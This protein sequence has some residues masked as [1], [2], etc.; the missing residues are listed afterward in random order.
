MAYVTPTLREES[1]GWHLEP[2]FSWLGGED[3]QLTAHESLSTCVQLP[4][5]EIPVTVE[6]RGPMKDFN[7][8]GLG[9]LCVSEK[10]RQTILPFVL[11]SVQFIPARLDAPGRWYIANLLRS[12]DC[13][14]PERS[15]LL[16][17]FPV[18]HPRAGDYSSVWQM[19]I[20]ESACR[21][22]HWFRPARWLVAELMSKEAADAVQNARI[23]GIDFLPTI[24]IP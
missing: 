6:D 3:E 7:Q 1:A 11:D 10:F 12:V 9:A 15:V 17:S 21:G 2:D 19:A 22:L 20:R 18:G 5:D 13:I 16:A 8:S 23:T 4:F 24:S 14:D